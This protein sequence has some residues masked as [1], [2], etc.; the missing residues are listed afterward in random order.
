MGEDTTSGRIARRQTSPWP[1]TVL[2]M[3]VPTCLRLG[4]VVA[5]ATLLW[6]CG[7][8]DR[9]ATPP[10]G[11]TTSA[12][13]I[14]PLPGAATT[15]V[16]VNAANR[17]TALL[18]AVRAARHP[19]FERVVFEFRDDTLPGYR[20]S[21]VRGPIRQDGS[22]SP[23]EV[24]GRFLLEVRLENALD[25]DLSQDPVQP[26]YTGPGRFSP[27]TS[28][29]VELVRS[30]AFEGVLTWVVGLRDQVAFKVTTL[31]SPARLVVD[32]RSG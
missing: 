32:F 1:I 19:G 6:A 10:A 23:V 17:R 20:V 22:G 5:A 15:P 29:V 11:T 21:Y 27:A 26:T 9:A 16:T 30:G 28:E 8:D 31:D 12:P 14:D 7:D 25:A 2:V 24:G 18:T 13:V 4:A 3:L